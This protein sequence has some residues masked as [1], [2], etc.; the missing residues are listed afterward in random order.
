MKFALSSLPTPIGALLIVCDDE[1]RMRALDWEDY[2]DRMRR[3]LRLQ[4]GGDIELREGRAPERMRESLNSYFAGDF[5]ALESI[6]VE[7]GGTVFQRKLWTALRGI[8]S[9]QTSTYAALAAKIG[10][11]KAVRAVGAANGANPIS[12]VLPCHRVIGSDQRL[13]GYGG[14]LD[15]KRWLLTHEGA[16]FRG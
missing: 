11:P 14:G 13:T 5:S 9:G 1:E 7:T 6:A 3:L 2:E 15:R 10:V 8:P 16:A 12:I 4:Y